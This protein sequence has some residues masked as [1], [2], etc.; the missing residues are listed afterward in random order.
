MT[1]ASG[2]R[3]RNHHKARAPK[4]WARKQYYVR[5]CTDQSK[6]TD[7]STVS[8]PMAPKWTGNGFPFNLTIWCVQHIW[9]WWLCHVYYSVRFI[10]HMRA[11]AFHACIKF[12]FIFL[13]VSV[14]SLCVSVNG[15]SLSVKVFDFFVFGPKVVGIEKCNVWYL[16]QKYLFETYQL[17]SNDFDK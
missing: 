7:Q 12:R 6:Y 11:R 14:C 10:K 16:Y 1:R 2:R 9:T 3:E 15:T 5:V 4:N 17:I 13:R 8:L